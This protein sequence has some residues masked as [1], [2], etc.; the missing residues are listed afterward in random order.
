MENKSQ[1]FV[2]NMLA[3]KN[4]GLKHA[5]LALISVIVSTSQG[6]HYMT[7]TDAKTMN[8]AILEKIVQTLKE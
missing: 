6:V 4:H 2:L 7:H 1:D 8:L 5:L 3:M